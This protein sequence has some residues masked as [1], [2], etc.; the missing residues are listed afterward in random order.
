MNGRGFG[1]A[2]FTISTGDGGGT[3]TAGLTAAGF[4]ACTGL[5][6]LTATVRQR[7]TFLPFTVTVEQ[8]RVVA[9]LGAGLT[10]AACAGA[11]TTTDSGRPTP[12]TKAKAAIAETDTPPKRWLIVMLKPLH[13][14]V[15]LPTQGSGTRCVARK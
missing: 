3:S 13:G 12:A 4:G 11:A 2:F 7:R 5:G 15:A 14:I 8:T 1:A 9:G 10:G 6:G